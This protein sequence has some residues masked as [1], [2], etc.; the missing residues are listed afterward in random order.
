[1]KIEEFVDGVYEAISGFACNREEPDRPDVEGFK[2][3][4]EKQLLEYVA[5]WEE[6]YYS[7]E[8]NRRE[9]LQRR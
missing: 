5:Q 7:I 4:V 2:N 9:L 1:M 6:E 8:S 3:Y